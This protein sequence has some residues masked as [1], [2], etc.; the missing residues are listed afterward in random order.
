MTLYE[1]RDATFVLEKIE[2]VRVRDPETVYV[3]TDGRYP[4]PHRLGHRVIVYFDSGRADDFEFRNKAER[5]AKH[6]E[7]LEAIHHGGAH[8]DRP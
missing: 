7:L 8:D 3:T 6:H 4:S 1:M 5:D 2:L